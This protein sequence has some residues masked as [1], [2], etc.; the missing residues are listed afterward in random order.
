MELYR[1]N[2]DST[3]AIDN[4]VSFYPM[5][6][7]PTKVKVQLHTIGGVAVYGILGSDPIERQ[8]YQ[9]WRPIPSGRK[10]K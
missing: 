10:D 6:S 8:N 9:G 5:E 2:A 3:V 4:H 1:L 7:C